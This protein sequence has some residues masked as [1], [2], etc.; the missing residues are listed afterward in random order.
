MNYMS[1]TRSFA[2]LI[3]TSLCASVSAKTYELGTDTT[4][5]VSGYAG[6][7]QVF[8]ESKVGFGR[9]YIG[10]DHHS[11]DINSQPELGLLLNLQVG[12]RLTIYNQ[13]MYGTN[14]NDILAYSF[15]NF[16]LYHDDDWTVD[17][18]GGRVRHDIGLYGLTRVNP[19]TRPGIIQPQAIYWTSLKELLTSGTGV[20]GEIKYKDFSVEYDVSDP[21]ITDSAIEAKE[22]SGGLMKKF[23]TSFGSQHVLT[24]TYDTGL[25]F[26]AKYNWMKLKAGNS[27]SPL[28]K[29]LFG[30]YTE[31]DQLMVGGLEY[32]KGPWMVSGEAVWFK[33]F[34]QTW[35]SKTSKIGPNSSGFSLTTSYDITENITGR[36][37]YNEYDAGFVN[38]KT[39]WLSY[40]RDLNVGLNWHDGHWQVGVEG[41]HI[42]GARWVASDVRNANPDAF[43]DWWM[44]ATNVVYFFD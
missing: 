28:G 8:T 11:E 13:F 33:G 35:T 5:D 21:S 37:N 15:A 4:L 24:A 3:L 1:I 43:K 30:Q 29:F 2:L 31:V 38:K 9:T 6:W 7:R 14:F 10:N 20:V 34:A 27:I 16:Q 25:G 41:H 18:R 22:W 19:R 17:V 12:K 42:N 44:I 26:R 36:I 23:D 32:R 39:P 40:A